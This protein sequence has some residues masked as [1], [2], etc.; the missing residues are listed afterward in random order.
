MHAVL[1]SSVIVS[2]LCNRRV[3]SKNALFL[4]CFTVIQKSKTHIHY[5]EEKKLS[6][7]DNPWTQFPERR[8]LLLMMIVLIA[9]Q[10]PV[11]V[12]MYFRPTAYS[13][14]ILRITADS[15]IGIGT[16][17]IL[18]IWLYILTGLKYHTSEMAIKRAE[19]KRRHLELQ[20]TINFL[21]SSGHSRYDNVHNYYEDNG[22]SYAGYGTSWTHLRMKH[23]PCGDSWPG[24]IVLYLLV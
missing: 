14:P 8:Y 12:F 4:F 3:S 5:V 15:L 6:W 2:I 1:P 11:L 16:H 9:F 21:R 18:C 7:F 17:G 19:N 10:N 22:E 20:K 13:S 23:D 24:E